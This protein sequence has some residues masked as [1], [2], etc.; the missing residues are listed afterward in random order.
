[1]HNIKMT[2]AYEGTAY[3]G[4]QRQTNAVSVQA[5]LEECL[6]RLCGE[7]INLIG[8]GR[9][10]AGVHALG[11][12][13]NFRT[14]ARIPASRMAPAL[15]NLLP[16]DIAVIEAE[17]VEFEFHARQAAKSKT[18]TY[19]IWRPFVRPVFE[20][21]LVYHF[22]RH[23]DLPAIE[24]ATRMLVGKKDFA[25]FCSAGSFVRT[26]TRTILNAGWEERG[27]VLV[28]TVT[29]D[30]FL[31]HMVRNIVGTLI[32]VGLGRWQPEW[33]QTLLQRGDRT[34]AGPTVPPGGLFLE[35]VDY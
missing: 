16:R 32:Q 21:G 2:I 26:S 22:P 19:R 35:R 29:A 15:N 31:Y 5:V 11:Q 4:F 13:A 6:N 24:A 3:A 12:V 18:Y 9:T 23:L 20:R 28:F 30:G 7:E 17:E 34:L 14:G 25:T 10:D 1:M 27:E 8:A 33:I